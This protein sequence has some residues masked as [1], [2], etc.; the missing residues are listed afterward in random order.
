MLSKKE[1][2]AIYYQ[3]NKAVLNE[4]QKAK[5]RANPG[6]RKGEHFR[7]GLKA[8]YGLTVEAYEQM[9]TEQKGLCAICGQPET[10]RQPSGELRNLAVD[11]CHT[12]NKVRGL[13]CFACNT[14]IGMAKD[15][16]EVLE[17]AIYYLKESDDVIA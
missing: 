3:E 1:R 12:T 6:V 16:I 10:V 14:M 4:K 2:N 15:R 11:H 8:R 7:Y 9:F 17:Q 13:L 5:R